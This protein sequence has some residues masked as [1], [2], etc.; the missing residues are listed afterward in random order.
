MPY[1]NSCRLYIH[2]AAM[3]CEDLTEVKMREKQ[4]KPTRGGKTTRTQQAGP[5]GG[6]KAVQTREV[7]P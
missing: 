4:N 7:T 2:L 1:R 6:P 5:A 3:Y